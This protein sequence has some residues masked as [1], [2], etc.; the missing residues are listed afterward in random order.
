MRALKGEEEGGRRQR[1]RVGPAPH[2]APPSDAEVAGMELAEV[3]AA[4]RAQM[5]VARVAEKACK[6]LEV[7]GRL[8]GGAQAAGDAG[9]LEAVVAAMR[10]HSDVADVQVAGCIALCAVSNGDDAAGLARKQRAVEA[11]A[12]EEVVAAL[13]V[14]PQVA[15]VQET[16][17]GALGNVCWGE[18]AAALSRHQRAAAA[19]AIE[20]IVAAM[21]AHAQVVEVQERGCCTLLIL[22]RGSDDAAARTRGRL[23]LQAGGRTAVVDAMEAHPEDDGVQNYGQRVL[24][25]LPAEV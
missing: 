22:C 15:L 8:G 12:I 5:A 9:A 11:G 21:R 13:R 1:Q 6:R 17:C 14:H 18:D 3:V 20:E 10:A 25:K 23:A 7:L 16:G 24:D 4:L 2:D 19:G